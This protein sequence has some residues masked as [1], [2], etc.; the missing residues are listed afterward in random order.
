MQLICIAIKCRKC[1]LVSICNSILFIYSQ[2]V[3]WNW[4]IC[5][6]ELH[7]KQF[8]LIFLQECLSN[9]CTLS[10][11]LT[12]SEKFEMNEEV[13]S[14]LRPWTIDLEWETLRKCFRIESPSSTRI[15]VLR[16]Q[17]HWMYGKIWSWQDPYSKFGDD[18]SHM[19][20]VNVLSCYLW[21][22]LIYSASLMH[23]RYTKK[24]SHCIKEI[25]LCEFDPEP[26]DM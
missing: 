2:I 15:L 24:T 1:N 26:K 19:I 6:T 12:H 10:E 7:R 9:I 23:R 4:L 25:Y 5:C 13:D 20:S 21:Q 14:L 17:Q 8:S 22:H 18:F 3:G 11:A 16:V